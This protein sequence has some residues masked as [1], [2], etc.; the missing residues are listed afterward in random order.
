MSRTRTGDDLR[1]SGRVQPLLPVL[2][3]VAL[4]ACSPTLEQ[5]PDLGEAGVQPAPGWTASDAEPGAPSTGWI[6]RLDADALPALVEEALAA[7]QS[8]RAVAARVEVARAQARIAGAATLPRLDAGAGA[9]RRGSGTGGRR[10]TANS[11]D[12]SLTTSWEVDLWQRLSDTTRAGALDALGSEADFAAARLSLAASV[13]RAWFDLLEAGQQQALAQE[14]VRNFGDNLAVVED[15]FRAGL[16]TALDVHL[17]RANLAGAESRLEA[18][19]EERDVAAR[20]LEV[21]LGRYP[22]DRLPT[23]AELPRLA[24]PVPAGLPADLL[25]RRPDLRAARL[26]LAAGGARLDAALKN[27]L[28]GLTL[29]ATGGLSSDA[30]RR[31]LDLDSLLFSIAADLAAPLFRG[32]ELDAERDLARA[33]VREA[34]ADYAQ[35]VLVAL[36]EVESA[37][38]AESILARQEAALETAA[39]ESRSAE[40]LALERYRSGLVDIV[41]WLEARRRAFDARSSLL[42]VRN[43]RLQNRVTLHLALGGDFNSTERDAPS[44]EGLRP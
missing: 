8:L 13:A 29:S 31:L 27:R 39:R 37:L 3:T 11:F 43:R 26:R 21:L 32:G 22:A 7:N 6:D 30:L 20:S 19:R 4:T 14:T 18:R 40:A 25:E 42:S 38:T 10:S 33:R 35:S 17:E 41:T 1:V 44:T 23:G 5:L 2:V 12:T 9:S 16:Y 15:G 36:R 34:L 28:P 24:S